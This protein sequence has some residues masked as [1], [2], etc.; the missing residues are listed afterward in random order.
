MARKNAG[1]RK[2][3]AGVASAS[4]QFSGGRDAWIL[5][6]L[7]WLALVFAWLAALGG[8]S[9]GSIDWRKT[10]DH[11]ALR[12][13]GVFRDLFGG[14]GYSA[15][16]W[17]LSKAPSYFPDFAF[18]WALFALGVDLQAALYIFPL[19]QVAFAAA[20]WI[21]VCDFLFGKSP[22]RRAAVL[23]AHAATFLS[24]AWDE[25]QIFNLQ[26]VSVYHYGAWACVPWLLWLSLRMLDAPPPSARPGRIAALVFALTI[27]TASNLL[28]APWF[29]IPSALAALL[30]ARFKQ[31]AVFIAVLAAGT[32]L[33][34]AVA[35][36]IPYDNA[37][38]IKHRYQTYDTS[39]ASWLNVLIPLRGHLVETVS[40]DPL[41]CM[42]MLAFAAAL[43]VK[44]APKLRELGAKQARREF[45]PRLFVLLLILISIIVPVAALIN[46]GNILATY[47]VHPITALR[48]LFPTFFFP[49]FV[50]WA[51]LEWKTPRWRIR[52]AALAA[53]ACAAALALSVPKLTRIDFAAMDP[54]ATPFQKCFAE[55]ARRLEWTSG[56][57]PIHFV[58]Q[59]FANPDAGMENYNWV[60]IKWAEAG[61]S[62]LLSPFGIVNHNRRGEEAQFVVSNARNGRIF[63]R[64][65]RTSDQGCP[66][67]NYG[68]C[69]GWEG[70]GD[71]VT[72]GAVKGA[73]GEPAEIVECAG[74]GLYHYDPPLRFEFSD[75]SSQSEFEF[76]GNKF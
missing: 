15:L 32:A 37:V 50:G 65:P 35:G 68:P 16:D 61:R 63:F 3:S 62:S 5:P 18:Q 21:L 49:L 64:P 76:I 73:F 43:C 55:N 52:P 56:I 11:D 27:V 22:V 13:Y 31:S 20:G 29:L 1:R 66:F 42:V 45:R 24:L 75:S 33:G 48:Y 7:G 59:M 30:S 44:L 34:L 19:T 8:V 38:S 14:E 54:F 53:A 17:W 9:D 70:V 60:R 36:A 10:F 4:P 23:L 72:D 71:I 39:W 26:M 25:S 6:A 41:K 67:D 57:A 46:H 40:R 51:L 47:L 12:S 2:R 74:I 69:L 58:L 28:I